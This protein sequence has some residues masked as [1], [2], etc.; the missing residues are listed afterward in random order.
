MLNSCHSQQG[1]CR[2]QGQTWTEMAASR[3]LVF[4][5]SLLLISPVG[6][7]STSQHEPTTSTLY[8]VSNH[9]IVRF[10]LYQLSNNVFF[11]FTSQYLIIVRDIH[12]QR[13]NQK[14]QE[15]IQSNCSMKG[16]N[17]A[18]NQIELPPHTQ[19][20]IHVIIFFEPLLYIYE[21]K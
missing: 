13:K 16:N 3:N 19:K 20:R 17:I 4:V 6:T 7:D 2:Q 5:S 21:H 1:K 8:C 14:H 11:S 12:A 10:I 15:I 9:F 18:Y